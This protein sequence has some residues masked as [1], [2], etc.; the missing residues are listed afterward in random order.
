MSS[1]LAQSRRQPPTSNEKK[2]KRPAQTQPG[3][4]TDDP[5]PPD[6]IGKPQ[7]AEKVTISTQIVNV[8]TVV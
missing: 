2:N 3:E 6:L 8:D 7:D 5:P 4:K 1:A